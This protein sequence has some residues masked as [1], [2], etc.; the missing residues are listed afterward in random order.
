MA[1]CCKQQPRRIVRRSDQGLLNQ[2]FNANPGLVSSSWPGRPRPLIGSRFL[3]LYNT[4]PTSQYEYLPA[5]NYFTGNPGPNGS[6][7]LS[8][9]DELHPGSVP[10]ELF[11]CLK[12]S[13]HM[14]RPL[15]LLF[16]VKGPLVKLVHFIGPPSLGK[17]KVRACFRNGG[18]HGTTIPMVCRSMKSLGKNRTPFPSKV[19]CAWP[20]ARAR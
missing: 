2:Y 14:V 20:G 9:P 12:P 8:S 11:L 19:G 3:F 16:Q 10:Q 15:E 13:A 1:L 4:T 18:M 5:F 6:D 7:S 17:A